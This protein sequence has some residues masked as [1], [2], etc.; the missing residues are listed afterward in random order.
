MKQMQVGLQLSFLALLLVITFNSRAED[1]DQEAKTCVV[2]GQWTTPKTKKVLSTAE[3]VKNISNY[4]AV[5]LGEFHDNFD[6]HQWQLHTLAALNATGRKLAIGLEMLPRLVQPVLDKWVAGELTEKEFLEQSRWYDFWNFDAKLYMPLFE[7][8]RINR[9]PVYALNIERKLVRQVSDVGWQ[10][11]PEEERSGVADPAP[12][13]KQYLEMLAGS[14]SMHGAHG[15]NSKKDDGAPDLAKIMQDPQFKRFVEGQQLWDR[16]MAE[17]IARVASGPENR[18]M[19]AMMGSGHMMN[20][21]GVPE[22]LTALGIKDVAVL[23]PW[24]DQFDCQE[25]G[26]D[27]ADAV[28]GL[29]PARAAAEKP[30]L[31]VGVEPQPQGVKVIKV[32]DQSI[33]QQA[34]ILSGDIIIE[35]AGKAKPQPNDVVSNVQAMAP[36]TWLPIVV[37]REGKR[38]DI[39]A[40][41]PRE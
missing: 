1:K 21:L 26:S 3:I 9:I 30:L 13:S 33:A 31:G 32:I 41:F 37:E 36:G 17:V 22:Q 4:Q 29:P 8:A 14:F 10:A 27:F 28:F 5:L 39:I 18:L 35:M 24:D 15:K 34:G 20:R 40:K 16:A 19:V 25:L 23:V 2:T 12:P 7:Y 11:I 6:H 38:V